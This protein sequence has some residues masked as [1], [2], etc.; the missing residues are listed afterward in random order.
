MTDNMQEILPITAIS[1]PPGLNYDFYVT[2]LGLQFIQNAD[3]LRRSDYI[4]SLL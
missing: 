4:P 1:G 3:Y 2:R